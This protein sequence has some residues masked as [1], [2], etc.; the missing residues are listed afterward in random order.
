MV[1]KITPL[2]ALDD[3]LNNDIKYFRKNP[4]VLKVLLAAGFDGYENITLGQLAKFYLEAFP[5]KTKGH[6]QLL[7]PANPD[8]ILA[9]Y[10]MYP[11]QQKSKSMLKL[12][13]GG[14][15]Q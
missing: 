2:E 6:L 11:K 15:T 8:I 9:E 10:K 14:K 3:L 1:L 13:K 5:K 7:D 12:I 4:E